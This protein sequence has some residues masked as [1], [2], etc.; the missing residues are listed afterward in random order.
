MK[1]LSQIYL[2]LLLVTVLTGCS[3]IGYYTQAI[4]GHTHLMMSGEPVASLI[5]D[6]QT[7]P[8]LRRKLTR[9]LQARQFAA[10][11]LAL[12]VDEAFLDYV[13]LG[14]HWV[15][16]NLVAVPEFSLQ[17]HRWC[18]PLL[19]CQA[20]RGYFN[21]DDANAE[22]SQFQARGYDTMVAGVTAYSTL[23]WFDDPLHSGFT[24]LP[25]DQMVALMFHELAHRVV[26]ISGDTTFN[27]SFATAVE[28]EGLKRWLERQGRQAQFGKALARL[29]QRHQTLALVQSTAAELEALYQQRDTLPLPRLR[30]RKAALFAD[31][32]DRYAAQS[33]H[34]DTPGPFGP[35]PVSLNNAHLALFRQYNQQVPAF[36]QLLKDQGG[37]FAAFYRAVKT[38]SAL[39]EASRNARLA[40][41]SER[42]EEYF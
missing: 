6:K 20:Y 15:V 32:Q 14:R 4:G 39:P 37:D 30:H 31:L 11:V 28:L 8:A 26:Y 23:G 24:A 10:D 2:L 13:E 35:P 7:P 19:G 17:P 5:A 9:S 36:R 21:L 38:L 3:T 27:E 16:V 41:L 1:Q 34:W 22:Q 40:D 42:F 29:R 33:E 12:P 25:D 18:Y